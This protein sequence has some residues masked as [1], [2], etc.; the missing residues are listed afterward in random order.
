MRKLPLTL[1][2]AAL[3]TVSVNANAALLAEYNFND[4]T[5]DDSAGSFDLTAIGGG[6]TISG[7]VL[8]VDGNN[9]SYYENTAN[10]A[11]ANPFTVSVWVKA[12][13]T[14]QGGFKGLFSNADDP[15]N[16]DFSWQIDN[17][18][19]QFR[20][21]SI[22]D[23]ADIT[24][25]SSGDGAPV[26]NRWQN[27]VIKKSGDVAGVELWVD[28]TLVGTNT[29]NP[30]GLQEFRVG[31]NRNSDNQY[32]GMYDKIQVY[33]S[34]ESI[35]DTFA[36]GHLNQTNSWIAGLGGDSGGDSTWQPIVGSNNVALDASES[37]SSTGID[38]VP[39][40]YSSVAGT[41]A[42]NSDVLF[43][44]SDDVSFE[45]LV[46]LDN[47]NGT[48]IIYE[49]GG[50]GSGSS[51]ALVGSE[52]RFTTQSGADANRMTTSTILDSSLLGE[53]LHI[54]AVITE[55]GDGTGTSELFVNGV[56]V[57]SDTIGALYNGW[58]GGNAWAFGR[59]QSTFA[60]SYTPT[61]NFDGDMALFSHYDYAL[62]RQDVID[63][64]R[65][66]GIPAPAALP[67]GLLMIVGLAARRRRVK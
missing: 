57:D 41:G 50:S 51:L 15:D 62:S 26:A 30:G 9:A 67:A 36:L 33:D 12:T 31:I 53:W 24:G 3:M 65:H 6:G 16:D 28:G 45:T 29:G 17:N 48:H 21:V 32:A 42:G 40:T 1:C 60:G 14:N 64:A 7:G 55:P 61:G 52:L 25:P 11:G 44:G 13:D 23:N 22:E 43:G 46:R 2:A 5:G 35:A 10:G 49:L 34:N 63:Q 66:F 4:G 20:V 18:N 8:T 19:G 27:V 39:N 59:N 38:S 58:A 54:V 47:L 56:S 37:L